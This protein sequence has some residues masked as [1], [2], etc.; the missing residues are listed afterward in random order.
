[1]LVREYSNQPKAVHL[2]AMK[3]TSIAAEI[4]EC[5]E[6]ELSVSD[7]KLLSAAKNSAVRAYAAYSNFKVGSA[8]SLGNGRMVTGNNQENAAY[9]SGLCAER[10]ALFFAASQYPA[11]KIK[12]I[13]ITNVPCGACR[14]AILEYEV[15]QGTPIRI[16]MQ[17]GTNRSRGVQSR[18]IYISE[19]ISNILP[20]GFGNK[21]LKKA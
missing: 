13:A 2:R 9:P 14:Q 10:V 5:S 12:A 7:R 11:A 15:K 4:M 18:T 3:R 19:G 17:R 6:K 21:E 20:L 16:I 1:M 8:V